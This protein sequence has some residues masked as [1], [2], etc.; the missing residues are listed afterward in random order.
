MLG[1][2]IYVID[3]R[4]DWDVGKRGA[5]WGPILATTTI[6]ELAMTSVET[7]VDNVISSL[8]SG[9][10]IDALRIADHGNRTGVQ[11]GDDWVSARTFSNFSAK[12]QELK[13]YFEDNGFAHLLGCLVGN[14]TG[15]M[16]LFAQTWNVDVYA[17]T[18]L[19]NG[20]QMNGGEWVRVSPEGTITNDVSWP[21]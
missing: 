9:K 18:G 14:E 8:D 19:T 12:F 5:F 10:K 7:M 2:T 4:I 21:R 15:L 11:F 17:G 16:H 6:G 1:N 20:F 13:P 3:D